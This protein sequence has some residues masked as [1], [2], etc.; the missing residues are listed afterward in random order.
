M[1]YGACDAVVPVRWQLGPHAARRRPTRL[2]I[3]FAWCLNVDR[4][5]LSEIPEAPVS[6]DEQS[7]SPSATRAMETSRA[8]LE[9]RV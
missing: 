8:I 6:S 3:C 9:V 4:D 7:A 5:A 2:M 1:R